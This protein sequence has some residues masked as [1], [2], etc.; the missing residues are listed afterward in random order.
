V[1]VDVGWLYVTVHNALR[2]QVGE[3]R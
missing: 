3:G 1:E 2:V